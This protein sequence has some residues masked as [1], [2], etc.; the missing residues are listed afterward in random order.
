M[1]HFNTSLIQKL[2]EVPLVAGFSVD[3]VEDVVPLVSS[4]RE[5]GIKVVELTLRTE[6]GM[7]A[8]EA[9]AKAQLDITLGVGTV[10]QPEQLLSVIS[11]GADF[12]VAPGL[13]E[14]VVSTAAEAGFPFAP[15][16]MTPS[17]IEKAVG[18]G[19]NVLK[20][21][22][23]ESSGGVPHLKSM[24]APYR[25]LG[26]QYF[27]LG[28]L[29]QD[30]MNQYLALDEVCTVGGSWIVKSELVSAGDWNALTERA[31]QAVDHIKT[32]I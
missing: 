9:L 12:A 20:F 17:E 19:C 11:A 22:P 2:S 24:A 6:A 10:L 25:H 4:L 32:N 29:N 1:S 8:V 31:R 27:P 26:I 14:E 23:A 28:G 21:F 18:L 3:R 5:G 13:N 30:N 7:A 15:G 16:V